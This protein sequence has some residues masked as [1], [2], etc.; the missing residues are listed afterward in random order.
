MEKGKVQ[1]GSSGNFKFNLKIIGKKRTL[2]NSGGGLYQQL[3]GGNRVK[4]KQL[5][6]ESLVEA[7]GDLFYGKKQ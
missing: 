2:S 6:K 4:Y 3:K 1:K 5:T 7:I